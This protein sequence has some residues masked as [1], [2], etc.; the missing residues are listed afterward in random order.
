MTQAPLAA[1]R[2]QPLLPRGGATITACRV[3]AEQIVTAFIDPSR[4]GEHL[5]LFAQ[6]RPHADDFADLFLGVYAD[7]ARERYPTV[8]ADLGP[9]RAA[10]RDQTQVRIVCASPL[11]LGPRATIPLAERLPGGY[12]AMLDR[13]HPGAT[14]CAWK[15]VRPGETTGMAWDGLA[16]TGERWAWLPKP[17]RMW[18]R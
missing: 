8:Y 11:L 7:Q 18:E 13:L 17:W 6:L 10:G 4:F 3:A 14:W 12:A 9:P 1:D 15:Y 2:A 5:D 16:W